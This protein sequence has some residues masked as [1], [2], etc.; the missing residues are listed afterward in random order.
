MKKDII[1]MTRKEILSVPTATWDDGIKGIICDSLLIVPGS[2]E[3]EELHDSG[4]RTM[5]FVAVVAGKPFKIIN[6]NSDAL[7][8]DG[9]GGYG[10]WNPDKGV[11]KTIEPRG[12][13]FDCLPVSGLIRLFCPG[14]KIK[15]GAA[16]SS[17]CVYAV[18]KG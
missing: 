9:H 4:Y 13:A 11:P 5:R 16:L 3:K 7:D 10:D 1:N 12:W 14:Y 18:K 8:L 15:A 17:F 2:G 6:G